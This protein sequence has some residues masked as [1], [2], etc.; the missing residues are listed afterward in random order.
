MTPQQM[1]V[2]MKLQLFLQNFVYL[3]RGTIGGSETTTVTR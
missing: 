3:L 2:I 1:I